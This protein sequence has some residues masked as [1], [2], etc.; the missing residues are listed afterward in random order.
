MQRA[1]GASAARLC[2]ASRRSRG[3][4]GASREATSGVGG[5]PNFPQLLESWT[6]VP[7]TRSLV[8]LGVPDAVPVEGHVEVATVA[9]S[10]GADAEML[11]RALRYVSCFAVFAEDARGRFGHTA[12]SLELRQ[13]GALHNK[14]LHRASAEMVMPY[15]DGFQRLLKDPSK[16]A[17][18]HLNGEDYFTEWLPRHPDSE[19][20]FGEFMSEASAPL[21]PLVL[22]S[23]PWPHEGTIVDVGGGNGHVLRALLQKFPRLSGVLFDLPSTIATAKSH[24]P[25]GDIMHSHRVSFS[26]GDFF[27]ALDVKADVYL[28]KRILH[29]WDDLRCTRLLANIHR[30]AHPGSRLVVIDMLVP[31]DMPN[32]YHVAKFFD[33]HMAAGYGGRER[34]AS[35][36]RAVAEAAGWH[37]QDILPVG[38]SPFACFVLQHR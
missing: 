31:E 6:A 8:Q 38:S 21:I 4:A 35:Q 17:F 30:S 23:F 11:R 22:E 19:V 29:D 7:V 32:E 15:I 18:K 10:V 14:V 9:E 1:L 5:A 27:T 13:G 36:M 20:L 28:I 33:I 3:G 12:T 25:A 24:W 34:T 2:G 37:L 26:P 16:S